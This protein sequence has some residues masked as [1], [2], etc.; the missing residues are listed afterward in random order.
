MPPADPERENRRT[1]RKSEL[2]PGKPQKKAPGTRRKTSRPVS[3][4]SGQG[5]RFPLLIDSDAIRIGFVDPAGP[6]VFGRLGLH[7][8]TEPQQADHVLDHHQAVRDAGIIP[9]R[10]QRN[11]GSA[12]HQR[13]IRDAEDLKQAFA[14]EIVDCLASVAEPAEDRGV[15]E[16]GEADGENVFAGI[17]NPFEGVERQFRRRER[18]EI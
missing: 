6:E 16:D 10:R 2:A 8:A 15:G 5:R 13:D 3:R 7:D 14:A 1:Q 18:R 9:D 12:E 17:R 11:D 4:P